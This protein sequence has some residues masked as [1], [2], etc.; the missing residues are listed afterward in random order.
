MA[1]ALVLDGLAKRYGA[2]TVTDNVSLAVP[3]NELH[4]IIGP[5]GAGKTTLIHQ[6]SGLLPSDS[7]RVL[8]SGEDITGLSMPARVRRGLVRSF[9]ITSILPGFPVIENVSLAVQARSGTSFRFLGRAADETALNDAAMAKLTEVG[10]AH[11]AA[12]PAG[13]LSHG[14]KR[15]LE[16]AVALAAAPRVLLL[17]EPLAGTSREEGEAL[18]ALLQRLR[19]KLTI[20]LIE[21][22]MEAVFQLADRVSVLVYG[23]VIATGT[24]AEIRANAEVRQAYLGEEAA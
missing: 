7:G 2:L 6:L 9:Q 16:L 19:G 13:A 14:E 11:R 5:N 21:H 23:Q 22:D 8:L 10:L 17:D 12:I 15:Q 4:A 20:L 18:I 24:P 3:E 1:D